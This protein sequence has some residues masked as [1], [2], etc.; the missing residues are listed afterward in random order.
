MAAL[1]ENSSDFLT[2]F[3]KRYA[4]ST[5]LKD[6]WDD[7]VK[8]RYSEPIRPAPFQGYCSYTLLVG[9]DTVVQLRPAAYKLDIDM[10]A[11]ACHIFGHLA[12]ETEYL[13]QLKGTDLHAFSMKKLPGVLLSQYRRMPSETRQQDREQIVRDFAHLQAQAWG[14]AKRPDELHE[15]KGTVGSSLALRLELMS[16]S[17]PMRFR[18]LA[19]AILRDISDIEAQPWVCTHGDF[20]AANIMVDPHSGALTGLLDWAEAEWL[21]FGIGLYGLEELLGEPNYNGFVYYPEASHLRIVFWDELM[22]LIP[23]HA[24][25]PKEI[26]IVRKAQRLGVLLWHGIAFDDGKLDRVVE[27]GKDDLEIQRLSLFFSQTRVLDG[28]LDHY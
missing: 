28:Q 4:S 2:P 21:P 27:E 15:G 11:T 23:K 9:E 13:G 12:P 6:D 19:R 10:T 5:T 3:F 7:F 24:Q 16:T 20:L 26:V 18:G 14:H 17:L 22:S 8:S 1:S 25:D